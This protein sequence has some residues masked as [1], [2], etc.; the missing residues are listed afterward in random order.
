VRQQD[1]KF[2]F[3][4]HRHDQVSNY[5]R[6]QQKVDSGF[7]YGM[8]VNYKILQRRRAGTASLQR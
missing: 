8:R 5:G 4:E 3:G 2:G 1:I 7:A 6:I